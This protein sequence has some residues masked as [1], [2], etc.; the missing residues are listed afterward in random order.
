MDCDISDCYHVC[1]ANMGQAS[2]RKL[3]SDG[4]HSSRFAADDAFKL[5]GEKKEIDE[6]VEEDLSAELKRWKVG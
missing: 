4:L 3:T 2:I 6:F 5:L 1:D